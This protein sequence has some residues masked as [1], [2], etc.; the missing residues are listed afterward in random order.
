MDIDGLGDGRRVTC[1]E[2]HASMIQNSTMKKVDERVEDTVEKVCP[3]VGCYGVN[4][5]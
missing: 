2:K 3:V 5:N 1:C 4:K